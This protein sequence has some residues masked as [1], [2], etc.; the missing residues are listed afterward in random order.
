MRLR[1]SI[2][3]N[4]QRHSP[5][6]DQG[7]YRPF[8]LSCGHIRLTIDR[9]FISSLVHRRHIP[10]YETTL[11]YIESFFLQANSAMLHIGCM[12]KKS[13]SSQVAT[14][15]ANVA[16]NGQNANC[17]YHCVLAV[18][19]YVSCVCCVLFLSLLRMLHALRFMKTP[20][21]GVSSTEA[22]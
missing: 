6:S 20:R 3:K 2:A 21:C 22:H 15:A 9:N 14:K 19:S 17:F 16:D 5:T 7:R 11:P 8:M 13:D 18:V 10:A 1:D 4:T 12:W